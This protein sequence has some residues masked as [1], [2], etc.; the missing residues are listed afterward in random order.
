MAAIPDELINKNK[1]SEKNMIYSKHML[2]KAMK[3]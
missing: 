2:I 3:S 1:L